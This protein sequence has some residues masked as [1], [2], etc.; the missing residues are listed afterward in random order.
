MAKFH[1]EL[2]IAGNFSV[3]VEAKTRAEADHKVKADLKAWNEGAEQ[4]E[5]NGLETVSASTV[6][7][8]T[9]VL[10]T[11]WLE[12]LGRAVNNISDSQ[13]D[14]EI[15]DSQDKLERLVKKYLLA[16]GYWPK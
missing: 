12:K 7:T 16:V 13:D 15:Y 11:N 6:S 3:D 10:Q 2:T 9:K 5:I 1:Y 8:E 4:D 14:N